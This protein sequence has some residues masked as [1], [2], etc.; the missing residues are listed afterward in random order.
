MAGFDVG[1][2]RA[3]GVGMNGKTAKIKGSAAFKA[4]WYR[5]AVKSYNDNLRAGN[6]VAAE[7]DRRAL[8][9]AGY[10]LC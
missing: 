1:K 8:E 9:R 7:G 5:D 2:G 10:T 3:I 6:K 4:Q